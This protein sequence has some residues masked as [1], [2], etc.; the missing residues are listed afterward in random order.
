M[1]GG[2]QT[3]PARRL[4]LSSPDVTLPPPPPRHPRSRLSLKATC[5]STS[6]RARLAGAGSS[7][8]RETQPRLA[9]VQGPPALSLAASAARRDATTG[10]AFLLFVLALLLNL[11]FWLQEHCDELISVS[12]YL[13]IS[14]MESPEAAGKDSS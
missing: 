9:A 13:L 4:F 11:L 12:S 3:A 1:W 6:T 2:A 10:L 5:A 14:G 7:M 8:R